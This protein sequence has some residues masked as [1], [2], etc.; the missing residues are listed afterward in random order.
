MRRLLPIGMMVGLL[1]LFTACGGNEADSAPTTTSMA[2]VATATTAASTT[3]IEAQA[4]PWRENDLVFQ[5]RISDGAT[6]TIDLYFPAEPEN[7]PIAIGGTTALVEEGFI[8]VDFDSD[9]HI[10]ENPAIEL[11]FPADDEHSAA[12]DYSSRGAPIRESAEGFAC[13]IRLVRARAAELGNDNPLVVL[14]SA[15]AGA[16]LGAHVALFGDTFDARWDEFAAEGG[17]SRQWDCTV[18]SGSTHVD[19][20]VG[21]AGT[22]DLHVPIYDS[23]YG[24]TYLEE[25]DP[26]LQAFLASAIGTN[27]DLKIRLIHGTYDDGI[28]FWN[29]ERF[30]AALAEAGYDVGEVIPFNGGHVHPPDEVYLPTLMEVLG[31]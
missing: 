1:A 9:D 17:P 22:Y 8:V 4:E 20:L 25:R 23:L 10:G 14:S 26:E 12:I 3:T 7:A 30:A 18:T 6:L 11:D 29:S 2:T 16:G 28:P 19:V 21:T 31:R 15:S 13:A 5:T 27:P 24:R